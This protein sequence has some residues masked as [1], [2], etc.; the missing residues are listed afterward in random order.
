MAESALVAASEK[1]TAKRAVKQVTALFSWN[2]WLALAY[3]FQGIALLV[4]STTQSTTIVSTFLTQNP[5]SKDH[6]LVSATQRI[7][8][9]PIT[10]TLAC[11]LFIAAL[12]HALFAGWLRAR[13]ESDLQQGDNRLGYILGTLLNA[14]TIV[15]A[16]VLSGITDMGTL[17]CVL[18]LSAIAGA[19]SYLS[20]R[21]RRRAM[22][23]LGGAA[24]L[25]IVAVI[26]WY[27]GAALVYGMGHLPGFVYGIFI[28][29]VASLSAQQVISYRQLT[30]HDG[31][32]GD[33]VYVQRILFSV[34]AVVL[35]VFT[36]QVFAGMLRP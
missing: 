12:G 20:N 36:W 31:A 25:V 23:A 14:G 16:A 10:A 4:V 17:I 5:L 13:Y 8:D 18:A 32:W 30:Q 9:L 29:L 26:A 33:H 19:A 34:F 7:F 15:L 28:T 2:K 6:A 22:H 35:T 3:A 1:A 11:I 21:D 24:M 27:M